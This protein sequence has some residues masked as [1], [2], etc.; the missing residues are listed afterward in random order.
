MFAKNILI[1]AD[2]EVFVQK[3]GVF[4]SGHTFPCGSKDRPRVVAS[5]AVQ[6]D[7]MAL[8][9]NV[10]PAKTR[11]AFVK[12]TVKVFKDLNKIVHAEDPDAMLVAVPTANFGADYIGSM[13]EKVKALGC[14]PDFN[15]YTMQP[16]PIPNA[17]LPFRTGSGH[18]HVGFTE[19]AEEDDYLHMK[20]CCRIARQLD[21]YLGLP[22][23]QWDKDSQRRELYGKA[24]AFR[25]KSYGMEYRVLSNA[26]VSDEKLMGF[27]YD[28]TIAAMNALRA[29]DDLDDKHE[30]LAQ[31][32]INESILDWPE[33]FPHLAHLVFE[34]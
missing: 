18:V 12:N 26:W 34:G 14:N 20:A 24:G 30:G 27:V 23:L 9:F 8:E 2:P 3:G 19:G 13:P 11:V 32:I 31:Q 29:G 6:V 28:R 21:Y 22:S 25:P 10:K 7:G 1:G 16:N 5:G 17:E 15:G 33:R 4:V